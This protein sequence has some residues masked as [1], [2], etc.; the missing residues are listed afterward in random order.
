M[1]TCVGWEKYENG[2]RK[3]VPIYGR[4]SRFLLCVASVRIVKKFPDSE[5]FFAGREAKNLPAEKCNLYA[6]SCATKD[7]NSSLWN[8]DFSSQEQLKMPH[9]FLCI[10]FSKIFH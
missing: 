8:A 5:I 1:T 6:I 2:V 10:I 7:E 9:I 3:G 4:K